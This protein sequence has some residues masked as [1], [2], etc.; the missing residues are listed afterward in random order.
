MSIEV[1]EM[2]NEELKELLDKHNIIPVAKD[3]LGGRVGIV[4][5]KAEQSGITIDESIVYYIAEHIK[6]NTRQL[7]GV[8]KKLQAHI[9]IQNHVPSISVVQ[10]IIKG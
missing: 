5:K 2:E 1:R 3:F 9:Q 7:E 4:N 6:M 8:V 10:S